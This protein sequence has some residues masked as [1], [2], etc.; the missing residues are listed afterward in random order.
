[1][2]HPLQQDNLTDKDLSIVR[3]LI[4]LVMDGI[5]LTDNPKIVTTVLMMMACAITEHVHF[6]TSRPNT[7]DMISEPSGKGFDLFSSVNDRG[8][9]KEAAMQYLHYL[10][11]G[12]WKEFIVSE[13]GEFP[14]YAIK[15][16]VGN[17]DKEKFDTDKHVVY[18]SFWKRIFNW[19]KR[20]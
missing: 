17:I 18:T 1:M 3:S 5:P 16:F 6:G 19:F 15:Q 7:V 14:K 20:I 12:Q 13:K 9:I 4:A 2:F 8:D 10:N 11:T